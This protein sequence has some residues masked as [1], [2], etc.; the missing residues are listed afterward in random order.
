MHRAA[1]RAGAAPRGGA[2]VSR[3]RH[4]VG[5]VQADDLGLVGQARRHRRPA[6][7]APCARR[8]TTSPAAPST[9]CSSTAQ[10][11]TWP[12]K[13]SPS[14]APSCAPSIRPGMSASTNSSACRQADD[15]ELRVQRG[16]RVVGDLRPRGG[17]G[18]EERGSCRRSA[19][20]PARHRR[21]ASAA[22]RPSAPRPASPC[23]RGA[24]RGWCEVLKWAL[25]KPPSPP[26]SSTTRLPGASRS[27]SRVSWSSAR[28]C[29]ADRHLDHDVVG[30]PAPVRSRAR[31][32]AALRAR[33]NA[34]CSGSRSAC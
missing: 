26:R 12:R 4:G 23:R 11:S 32:V 13:R 9:R 28:I 19:G 16:E 2:E 33:G 5:L 15:A 30:A 27:A 14:P 18:G 25:P 8:R 24:A 7:R 3:G 31:A 34:A 17:D 29:G 10:R 1:G 6:P 21:S 22:A 20:R